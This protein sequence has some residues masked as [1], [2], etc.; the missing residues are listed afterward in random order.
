MVSGWFG[1]GKTGWFAA[2]WQQI[3]APIRETGTPYA[4]ILGN[5]DDEAD[6]DRRQILQLDIDT[7]DSLS[8][9]QQGPVAVGGAS[10]YY[11]DILPASNTSLVLVPAARLWFFDSM[12]MGCAGLTGSWGCVAST[13][14]R[15][16]ASQAKSLTPVPS[17]A[18]VHIPLPETLDAWAN[19]TS[20]VGYKGELSNCPA[21]NTGLY[22]ILSAA[23]IGAVWSGHDHDNDYAGC[24]GPVVVGQGRKT[25]YGSYGNLVQG[26]RIIELQEGQPVQ[27]AATWI[28]TL[29]GSKQIQMALVREYTG[30]QEICRSAVASPPLARG[31]WLVAGVILAWLAAIVFL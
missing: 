4:I 8:R 10:N 28:A 11:L 23:G 3:T 19:V 17:M 22:S 13:A 27:K 16:A 21:I 7:G 29:D 5:H 24:T 9:T 31:R 15:W 12:D 18:F 1:A 25:G 26:A 6:L 20:A 14:V 2:Q 30:E